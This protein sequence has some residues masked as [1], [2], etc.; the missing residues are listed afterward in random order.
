MSGQILGGVFVC[1][2]IL[3]Q[4]ASSGI[5]GP[6]AKRARANQRSPKRVSRHEHSLISG[7]ELCWQPVTG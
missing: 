5:Y 6:I 4:Q 2:Y 3:S 7:P 1:R